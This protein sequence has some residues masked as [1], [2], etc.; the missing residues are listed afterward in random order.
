VQSGADRPGALWCR[1]AD[2][3]TGFR[4]TRMAV[5]EPTGPGRGSRR[6]MTTGI[7]TRNA[8][9]LPGPQPTVTGAMPVHRVTTPYTWPAISTLRC[10]PSCSA[11]P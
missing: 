4:H 5:A 2:P 9:E 1:N 7:E 11:L 10:P 6:S 8:G 3:Y